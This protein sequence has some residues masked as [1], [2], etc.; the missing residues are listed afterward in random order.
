M[1]SISLVPKPVLAA[2]A[3]SV[4]QASLVCTGNETSTAG[5]Y[6]YLAGW[7]CDG[8]RWQQ[9]SQGVTRVRSD[10]FGFAGLEYSCGR[11]GAALPK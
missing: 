9:R 8:G 10:E 7:W 3:Y 1:Y 4:K 2:L 5:T 11:V 6:M